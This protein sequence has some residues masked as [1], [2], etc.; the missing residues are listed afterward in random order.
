VLIKR[1]SLDHK[2]GKKGVTLA[3]LGQKY[4]VT[5][6]RIRQIEEAAFTAL[7]K[8]IQTGVG[9]EVFDFLR[10]ELDTAGGVKKEAAIREA[11]E[12]RFGESI[13]DLPLRFLLEVEGS[14]GFYS[15]DKDFHDF[16]YRGE[17]QR[18]AAK[19]LIDRAG[20]YLAQHKDEA[21]KARN[22]PAVIPAL[23]RETNVS[24]S[25]GMNYL[26][27]SKKFGTSIYGD[28]GLTEWPEINPKTVRDRAYLILKE[29]K[30]PLHFREIAQLI[31]ER[32]FDDKK[33]HASTAHNE[34]IKDD[35]FVLVGR[36][37]YGLREQ[38]F[39]PGTAREVISKILKNEGPQHPQDLIKLVL[40]ERLFKEN[41]ILLN[42]QNKK[43]FRRLEDGRYSAHQV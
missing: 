23:A 43:L 34:L 39:T 18:E 37:I 2:G 13:G 11:L 21:L 9:K 16:W 1:F 20:K 41:T 5:R 4:G 7:R 17:K 42:L 25:V 40:K 19:T 29:A 31:K 30:S 33:V 32:R 38:G 28:F 15:E 12:A 27:I 3:E 6:E 22:F 8:R 35:R 36:G 24:E 26:S 14:F 10:T